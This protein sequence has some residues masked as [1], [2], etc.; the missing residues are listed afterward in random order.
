M[1]NKECT[2]NYKL[3][4]LFRGLILL[5]VIDTS[6]LFHAVVPALLFFTVELRAGSR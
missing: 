5:V 2:K 6:T 3:Y 1:V 4:S